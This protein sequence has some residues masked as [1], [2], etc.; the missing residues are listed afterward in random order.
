MGLRGG[1]DGDGGDAV[2]DRDAVD[3]AAAGALAAGG[4]SQGG[5]GDEASGEDCTAGDAGGH[6]VPVRE[7]KRGGGAG[8]A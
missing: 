2:L 1:A 6:D 5:G 8:P 7:K 4:Q 3:L